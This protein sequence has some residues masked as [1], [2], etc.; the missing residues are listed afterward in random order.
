M[1]LNCPIAVMAP[2][3]IFLD[4]FHFTLDKQNNISSKQ[5][6]NLS[7]TSPFTIDFNCIS[8]AGSRSSTQI[9]VRNYSKTDTLTIQASIRVA[10]VGKLSEED[11]NFVES[12]QSSRRIKE[13]P[14]SNIHTSF[15][16]HD[17]EL[18][19]KLFSLNSDAFGEGELEHVSLVS[20][21]TTKTLDS[22]RQSMEHRSNFTEIAGRITNSAASPIK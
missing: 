10:R 17:G 9:V 8:L 4:S 12:I 18:L 5:K 6:N 15:I 21:W 1:E 14:S 3:G 7:T 22:L 13:Y 2:Q 16:L 20:N 19:S 11:I